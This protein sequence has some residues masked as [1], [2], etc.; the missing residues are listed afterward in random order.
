MWYVIFECSKVHGTKCLE[1]APALWSDTRC[2][3]FNFTELWPTYAIVRP[4][5]TYG[6]LVNMKERCL[7]NAWWGHRPPKFPQNWKI[8]AHAAGTSTYSGKTDADDRKLKQT[9][10]A[11]IPKLHDL[12][13]RIALDGRVS[14]NKNIT[15]ILK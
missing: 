8:Q 4:L 5:G 15:F 1:G 9:G 11:S 7:Y 10:Q 12:L 13:Y 3:L 14:E 2:T 6:Q